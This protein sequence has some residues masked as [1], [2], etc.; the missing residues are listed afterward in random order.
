MSRQRP[1]HLQLALS[2]LLSACI[3]CAGPATA[4][5]PEAAPAAA[6]RARY[7]TLSA[8]RGS[9]PFQRPL[10]VESVESAQD[11]KGDIFALVDHPFA[12][13]NAAL[14]VPANWCDVM[15][16]HIN[17]KYCRAV[18]AGTRT[19]LLVNIGKKTEQ[20]LDDAYRV[21]FAYRLAATTPEYLAVQLNADNGPLGTS[22]YRI[23]L[24]A[25]PADATRTLLHLSYSY[26]YGLS[27]RLGMQAYL[28]T[29]GRG[30]V[31]FTIEGKQAG[32]EPAYVGGVRGV[33]E[34]NTMRYFLAIDAYLGALDAAPADQLE[35]R[36][37]NWYAATEA[38][39]RQLHEV[40]RG[41]YLTM[42]RS[43]YRRQQT[44][45]AR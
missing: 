36:L 29:S 21:S 17:T 14:A 30:K 18:S 10:Y 28:A 24:E 35:K 20:A 27:G 38:Y 8:E 3:A 37:H 34:R 25:V 31:G 11:L 2:S 1:Q 26:A 19:T 13:V 32:G 45:E 16:L 23:V 15:I 12:N 41:D 33:I 40:E 4:A 44:V 42:K 43:E 9:S 7:A 39:A 22:N 5:A 6:L